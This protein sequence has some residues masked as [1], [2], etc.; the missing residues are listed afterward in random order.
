[1]LPTRRASAVPIPTRLTK[2]A[3]TALGAI[4][5]V[6][7]ANGASSGRKPAPTSMRMFAP[8]KP[9]SRSNSDRCPPRAG[10]RRP[11]TI[12]AARCGRRFVPLPAG[13]PTPPR[14]RRSSRACRRAGDWPQVP[15]KAMRPR[16]SI[17]WAEAAKPPYARCAVQARSSARTGHGMSSSYYRNVDY[18]E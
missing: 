10:P 2:E 14:A 15:Q 5:V 18:C 8:G 7:S 6:R 4:E 17:K 9:S 16:L 1:M 3:V 12:A 13:V 11:A